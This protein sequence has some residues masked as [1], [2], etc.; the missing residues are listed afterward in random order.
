[1]DSHHVSFMEKPTVPVG[2]K[3]IV[4]NESRLSAR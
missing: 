1:M 3:V 4:A 2:D